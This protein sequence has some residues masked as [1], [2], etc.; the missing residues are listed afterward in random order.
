MNLAYLANA[1]SCASLRA[2]GSAKVMD[3]TSFCKS[4]SQGL[5]SDLINLRL[6]LVAAGATRD[7]VAEDD[8]FLTSFFGLM[9]R[10][11]APEKILTIAITYYYHYDRITI[12]ITITIITITIITISL[13]Q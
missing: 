2:L 6:V 4:D 12:S 13:M 5:N 7:A 1:M 11:A 3:L 10:G 8:I 9:K